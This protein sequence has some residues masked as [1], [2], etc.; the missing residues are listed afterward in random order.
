MSGKYLIDTNIVIALFAAEVPVIQQLRQADEVFIPSV[1]IGELYYGAHKSS[2][3]AENLA[4][5]ADFVMH[6]V[7][8]SCDVETARYYGELKNDLRQ[9]GRPIPE[10]DLWIAATAIQHSLTLVSRDAHFGEIAGL[11]FESW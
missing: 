9:K 5:I 6:N 3:T 4:R 10:N 11:M 2:H 7:I 8:L 1:A